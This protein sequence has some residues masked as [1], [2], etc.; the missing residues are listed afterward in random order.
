MRGAFSDTLYQIDVYHQ[1]ESKNIMG[2]AKDY[3]VK[4]KKVGRA[5]IQK[6]AG[7]LQDLAEVHEGVFF[8][9]TDYTA[10]AKKYA[11]VSKSMLGKGISLY[12]LQPSFKSDENGR[13][14]TISITIN[15]YLPRYDEGE[16]EPIFSSQGKDKVRKL[17]ETGELAQDDIKVIIEEFYDEHG[18][19]VTT[20]RE[21]TNGN[22]GGGMGN[23]A[24]ASFY[25]KG[26]Y[27]DVSGHLIEIQGLTY[28]IPFSRSTE[29]IEIN[30]QGKS[31]LLVKDQYGNVNKLITDEQLK[32]VLT[33]VTRKK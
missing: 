13:I 32:G 24:N 2:E 27:I 20:V 12:N 17:I 30:A 8:S 5:D 29:K 33:E 21:L 26:H 18:R 10:P 22:I 7:A 11:E 23:N 19:I 15:Y 4:G 25:L 14:M 1:N 6:L 28:N 3:T 31:K 9:A 16:Y